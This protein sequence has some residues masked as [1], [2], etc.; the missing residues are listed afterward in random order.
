M[1]R[2]QPL[3]KTSIDATN[4]YKMQSILSENKKNFESTEKWLYLGAD[5]AN[6]NYAKIGI[7]MGDLQSR[8]YSSAN[9]SYYIF[10]AFKCRYN[11]TKEQLER[12]EGE[13]LK[14]L[15]QRYTDD[16]GATK[17]MSHFESKRSSECYNDI[18]FM[19]FFINLHEE[20]YNNH[21]NY[22]L[23]TGLENEYGDDMGEFLDCEFNSR[24]SIK[25]AYRLRLKLTR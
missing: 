25:E 5:D 17:R 6:K 10:C 12:I 15:D 7:T 20:L 16:D 18:D 23:I 3:F 19:D 8:S 11:I 14:A 22:F 13:V 4:D 21:S 9:P 2:E 1:K 24:I